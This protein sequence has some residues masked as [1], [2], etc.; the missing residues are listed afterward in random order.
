LLG[1]FFAYTRDRLR[2]PWWNLFCFWFSSRADFFYTI[3]NILYILLTFYIKNILIL[4]C[5]K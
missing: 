4:L 5:Y 2:R 1:I 3:K